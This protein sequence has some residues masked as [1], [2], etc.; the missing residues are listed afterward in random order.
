LATTGQ[1]IDQE[2]AQ[3]MTVDRDLEH[4]SSHWQV[5]GA[6]NTGY[7]TQRKGSVGDVI[8]APLLALTSPNRWWVLGQMRQAIALHRSMGLAFTQDSVRQ[9]CTLALLRPLLSDRARVLIIGDGFGVLAA[10]LA[11]QYPTATL[12]LVDISPAFD[13]QR[14]RLSQA[15]ARNED[16][17]RFTFT[18]A[19][20]LSAQ[21]FGDRRYDVAVNVASMQEMNPSEVARYFDFMRGRV[22][23][24][25]CCNRE[26]KTFPDGTVSAFD[27]Y[28]WSDRDEVLLDEPCPW[29]QWYV[30]YLPPFVHRYDGPTRH[31]LV[32][33]DGN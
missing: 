32:R 31:R 17:T 4:T 1:S 11:S 10:L 12:H 20:D 28:P 23:H 3:K 9:L 33:L 18:H 24:F 5:W 25:Y 13:E 16:G 6:R 7:G 27:E 21:R 22:T 26:R 2:G 19:G 30:S 15:F 29:H 14:S 8:G